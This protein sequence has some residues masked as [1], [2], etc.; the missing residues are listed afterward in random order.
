M[1]WLLLSLPLAI[2]THLW[3]CIRVGRSSGLLAVLTFFLG[4][5]GALWSLF[6]H[7]GDDETSV[8][9]P[10]LANLVFTAVFFV[11]AW[12][13]VVP[14]FEADA[15]EL[16]AAAGPI[17]VVVTKVAAAASEPA[18]AA[19]AVVTVVT[20]VTA[21]ASGASAPAAN[22][23]DTFAQLLD[24]A[25]LPHTVSRMPAGSA[26]PPGVVEAA[27]YA[28]SP[29]GSTGA[30]SS[31]DGGEVSVT[32]F[33]CESAAACRQLAGLHMQGD[34]RRRV[35]QHGLLLLSTPPVAVN[36][37]DLTQAAIAS[38]FRKLPS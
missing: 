28:V 22:P 11:T 1:K 6:K 27:L 36:E 12:Q 32:L 13:F 4:P 8:T 33:R 25:G 37:T 20:V 19:S 2:A 14:L 7:H 29:R 26:L 10:F 15:Q 34:A 30:A 16:R 31:A 23:V 17:P 21:A 38:A 9:V 5:I 24:G 18:S 35:L 3:L